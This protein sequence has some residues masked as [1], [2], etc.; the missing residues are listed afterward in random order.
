MILLL[1][2]AAADSEDGR[3]ESLYQ[4]S[5]TD[6][7]HRQTDIEGGAESTEEP[8]LQEFPAIRDEK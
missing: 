6:T 1:K 2:Q 4:S 5:G 8:S 7:G 3:N